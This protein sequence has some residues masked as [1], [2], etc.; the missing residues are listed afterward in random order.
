[1]HFFASDAEVSKF[2]TLQF[3][4]EISYMINATY[5]VGTFD[6][7]VGGM[8]GVLRACKGD[9]PVKTFAN[10]FGVDSDTWRLR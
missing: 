3:F 2:Q 4:T 9:K 8:V 10:S 7:N 1:V 6:S 5:F